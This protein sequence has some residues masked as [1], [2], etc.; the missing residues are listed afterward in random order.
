MWCLFKK[1][2]YF[3]TRLES[4]GYLPELDMVQK[5]WELCEQQLNISGLIVLSSV[6]IIKY[7]HMIST[8]SQLTTR[9]LL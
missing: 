4:L 5:F 3:S 2:K 1:S 9:A 7:V 8:R 6:Y